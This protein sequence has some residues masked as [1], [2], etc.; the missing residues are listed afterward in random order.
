MSIK[1]MPIDEH[2]ELRPKFVMPARGCGKSQIQLQLYD[3]ILKGEINMGA[4]AWKEWMNSKFGKPKVGI[5]TSEDKDATVIVED[6]PDVD[7]TPIKEAEEW[8]W[9]KGFK[10]T[11]KDMRCKGD[12]QYELGKFFDMNSED[13][14]ELCQSGFHFCKEL[15][16]VFDYYN[17]ENGNR[18]FEVEALVKKSDWDQELRK[19]DL[20][21]FS[22]NMP[23]YTYMRSE[24]KYAA[25]SICFV[26]E[27]TPDEVFDALESDACQW[28]EAQK[29]RAMET[30][31]QTVRSDIRVFELCAAGYS[32]AFAQ[33]IAGD[34]DRYKRAMAVASLP[35]VS[36]DV[37]VM[38]I[39]IYNND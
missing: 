35:D 30:S 10:G 22:Y 37:K 13:D 20:G 8:I 29:K 28:D 27:L 14:V 33:Y 16:S 12:Y 24:D 36:M 5:D 15:K 7:L 32:P 6:I 17:I 4:N 39:F 19:N 18:F 1:A 34:I 23:Y 11:N 26:R 3:A 31:I 9:V 2:G 25:K 21:Y 38:A